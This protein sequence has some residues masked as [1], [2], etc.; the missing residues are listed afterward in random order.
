MPQRIR[1]WIVETESGWIYAFSRFERAKSSAGA[2]ANGR[3]TI[4]RQ[5]SQPATAHHRHRP[6]RRAAQR[7]GRRNDTV[8]RQHGLGR[9][10]RCLK[11]ADGWA[12]RWGELAALGVNVNYAPVC[13]ISSN[14]QNPPAASALWR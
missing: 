3:I 6:G 5:T 10:A 11:L 9:D 1:E 4:N 12:R 13:D 8:P 2:G 7:P 14:P